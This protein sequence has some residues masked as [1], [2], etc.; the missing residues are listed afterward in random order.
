[1]GTTILISAL[2]YMLLRSIEAIV[3]LMWKWYREG[4]GGSL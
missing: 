1:M 3:G 4:K 2:T